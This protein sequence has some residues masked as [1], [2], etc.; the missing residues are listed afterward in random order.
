MIS[1]IIIRIV[2]LITINFKNYSEAW[3]IAVNDKDSKLM[4]NV[5]SDNIN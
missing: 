2:D 5:L 1:K 3:L 4:Q